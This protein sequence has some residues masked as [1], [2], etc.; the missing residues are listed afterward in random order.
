MA[1]TKLLN[2]F[3]K[4]K[5]TSTYDGYFRV[6]RQDESLCTILNLD[7]KCIKLHKHTEELKKV[8]VITVCLTSK[9]IND[10]NLALMSKKEYNFIH[11]FTEMFEK[12]WRKDDEDCILHVLNHKYPHLFYSLG[13]FIKVINPNDYISFTI[14]IYKLLYTYEKNH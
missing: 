7:D 14:D 9:E 1:G 4:L 12:A 11:C 6:I 13:F 8:K 2:C 5:D 3:V 10:I